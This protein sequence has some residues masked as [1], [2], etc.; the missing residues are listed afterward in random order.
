MRWDSGDDVI[1]IVTRIA[2]MAKSE[3]GGCHSDRPATQHRA[4]QEANV[5]PNKYLKRSSRTGSQGTGLWRQPHRDS[6]RKREKN[7]KDSDRSWD[8]LR[9]GDHNGLDEIYLGYLCRFIFSL[10]LTTIILKDPIIS[11]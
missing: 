8:H 2:T 10:Y 11:P 3:A 7:A 9:N 4:S 5:V 1:A 6:Q